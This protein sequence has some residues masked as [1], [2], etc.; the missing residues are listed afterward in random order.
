[1][2]A[3]VLREHVDA[4][5]PSAPLINDIKPV[6][7]AQTLRFLLRRAIAG[8]C[9][10][11][12]MLHASAED[13][14]D[15]CS[16]LKDIVTADSFATLAARAPLMPAGSPGQGACKGGAHIYDCRW[17]AHWGPDGVVADPL[18]ELGADIAA[19]FPD[20]RHDVNTATR[21]HFILRDAANKR[22]VRLTA[23]IDGP[24]A[25]RLIVVR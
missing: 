16:A 6:M 18:E 10:M 9:L 15:V 5:L 13:L 21:Q 23:T 1:L 12:P 19:C 2:I 24:S 25:L 20:V 17:K 3:H 11:A 8:A 7:Q 14:P 22:P 4:R